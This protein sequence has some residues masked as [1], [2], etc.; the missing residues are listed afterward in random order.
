MKS[1]NTPAGLAPVEFS[2]RLIN[3]HSCINCTY[4]HLS[5]ALVI[6]GEILQGYDT[7]EYHIY[8]LGNLNEAQEQSIGT[9]HRLPT[10]IRDLRLQLY[11]EATAIADLATINHA[12]PKLRQLAI[13][14]GQIASRHSAPG[15]APTG[16]APVEQSYQAPQSGA[17]QAITQPKPCSGCGKSTVDI[18]IPLKI[19]DSKADNL[20]L[21]LALRS[22]ERHLTGIGRIFIVCPN[23]PAWLKNVTLITDIPN[24]GLRKAVSIYRNLRAAMLQSTTKQVIWL[25]DDSIILKPTTAKNIKFYHNGSDLATDFTG[26]RFWHR[27]LRNTAA[28]LAKRN[29]LTLNCE[30]HMPMLFDRR[31]F[32]ALDA[33]FGNEFQSDLGLVS[34]SIYCNR[35]RVH[36]AGSMDDIKATLEL[37]LGTTAQI[38]AAIANRQFI[39]YDDK[40]FTPTLQAYLTNIFPTP[41]KYE[42]V[43]QAAAQRNEQKGK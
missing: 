35:Y 2:P 6:A 18:I 41:S 1:T 10:M 17:Q 7:P 31:K 11:P 27:I 29:Y 32:L 39:S 8:L 28:A 13:I 25:S 9:S 16:L 24:A 40:G 14:A 36:S 20:E 42:R 19:E 26:K 12:I 22:I 37:N 15:I 30:S 4:K 43:Q 23:P 38:T 3:Q 21:R 5:S 34:Y 33:E